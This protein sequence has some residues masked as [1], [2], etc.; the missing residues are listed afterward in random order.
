MDETAF[1]GFEVRLRQTV[2]QTAENQGVMLSVEGSCVHDDLSV[3]LATSSY[4]GKVKLETHPCRS[5]NS[6]REQVGWI[7]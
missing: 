5:N 4:G 2:G 6:S 3:V 1:R 7:S